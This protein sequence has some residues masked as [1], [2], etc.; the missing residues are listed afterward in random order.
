MDLKTTVFL[1]GFKKKPSELE[2]YFNFQFKWKLCCLNKGWSCPSS[3]ISVFS[4][5]N[6]ATKA[7]KAAFEWR[8][9]EMLIKIL[10]KS[11]PLDAKCSFRGQ[12]WYQ[13]PAPLSFLLFLLDCRAVLSKCR[14]KF[15]VPVGSGDSSVQSSDVWHPH[16]QWQL[17]A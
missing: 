8:T 3:R 13:S 10:I 2:W 4:R 16:V 17:R 15:C 9:I 5:E 6:S 12:Y 14:G 1:H 7:A 11:T